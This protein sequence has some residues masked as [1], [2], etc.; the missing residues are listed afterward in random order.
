[1]NGDSGSKFPRMRNRDIV[2][3]T[4]VI[5]NSEFSKLCEKALIMKSSLDVSDLDLKRSFGERWRAGSHS[6]LQLPAL[7]S[8]PPYISC[9]LRQLNSCFCQHNSW[10]DRLH[11]QYS[12]RLLTHCYQ[13]LS[14]LNH[15]GT[16]FYFY[17]SGK[18]NWILLM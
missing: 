1:M 5:I 2:V 17:Q 16:W 18:E 13:P 15:L 14:W 8:R 6:Q 4:A 3:G 7:S 10:S 9:Y 11:S 12:W